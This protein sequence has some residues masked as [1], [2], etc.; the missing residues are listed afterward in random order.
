VVSDLDAF[1]QAAILA[2]TIHTPHTLHSTNLN[3][4]TIFSTILLHTYS[5]NNNVAIL[6]PNPQSRS[7]LPAT[8]LTNIF[9]MELTY[10][11]NILLAV[12][13]TSRRAQSASDAQLESEV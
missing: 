1:H 9:S 12:N 2:N 4:S 7:L 8:R 10:T 5:A 11:P 3:Y 13:D 6:T